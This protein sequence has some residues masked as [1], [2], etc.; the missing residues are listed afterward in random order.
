M[1]NAPISVLR[2]CCWCF[3]LLSRDERACERGKCDCIS[4]TTRRWKNRYSSWFTARTNLLINHQL[5]HSQH[6]TIPLHVIKLIC[7]PSIVLFALVPRV[8]LM[9]KKSASFHYVC[10]S[11]ES[12][13]NNTEI[14]KLLLLFPSTL[15][16]ML[17]KITFGETP[18]M[19]L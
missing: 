19:P 5:R 8:L 14:I 17:L 6:D 10:F 16:T 2:W 18:L 13:V 4:F 1:K 3:S 11:L 7:V 15:P 12:A 9:P